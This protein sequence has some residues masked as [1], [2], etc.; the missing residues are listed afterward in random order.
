MLLPLDELIQKYSLN[1]KGVI[2]IGAHKGQE[3]PEYIRLLISPI[4]L[5]EPNP[6]VFAELQQ[7]VGKAKL[8]NVALA[9]FD[10]EREMFASKN[11]EG[12]S[13]S[14]LKPK[15]HLE[16]YPDIVFDYTRLT[17]VT[18]LDKLSLNRSDYNMINMDVQGAELLVLKGG[19]DFLKTIDYIYT[20]VNFAEVYENCAL[21]GDIDEFLS[22]YGF[23][24]VETDSS[25]KTWGDAL[26]V[27]KS[28][29]LEKALIDQSPSSLPTIPQSFTALVKNHKL[30]I[31]GI[32]DIGAH[33][34]TAMGE[35]L[36]LEIPNIVLIEPN[37]NAFNKLQEYHGRAKLFNLAMLDYQGNQEMYVSPNNEGAAD[38]LLR[39]KLITSLKPEIK[40]NG[41]G[42]V[43]VSSLDRLRLD[44]GMYNMICID[45][46]GTELVALNGGVE[47]LL[48][49]DYIYANVNFKEMYESCVLVGAL[50]AFLA[51]FQ[52]QRIITDTSSVGSGMALYVKKKKSQ[53]VLL[54][55]AQASAINLTNSYLENPENENVVPVPAK[56]RPHMQFDYPED[57]N[58][59]FEEWFYSTFTADNNKGERIYLPIFW[60]SFYVNNGYGKDK[61]AISDL[62]D[63][64][65]TLDTT[66]KYYTIVQYDNGIL[67]D[68]SKLDIK[69]FAMSGNRIDYPLPLIC[70]PHK[71]LF[72]GIKKDILCSFVGRT[73]THPIRQQMIDMLP[74]NNPD[75][76]I[77]TVPHT[78]EEYCKVLARSRYVLAP[79]GHG[80]TSFRI[81][82]ALQYGAVP[83]YISDDLIIPHRR[84]FVEG[85]KINDF[86]MKALS[87][88]INTNEE[89]Y[90]GVIKLSEDGIITNRIEEEVS[91]NYNRFYTYDKN[92]EIIVNS[93]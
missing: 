37:I 13:D 71:Y 51:K 85:I 31:S 14:L 83:I 64:I 36:K 19:K 26:Y 47:F 84:N 38:S 49:I 74:K 22:I 21:I 81:C 25:A 76:Y 20:E 28:A 59:P 9:D 29:Q 5:V 6:E 91:Y 35:Y 93:I 58:T 40:F 4:A 69:V 7:Y 63:F 17:K 65:D 89:H 61:A 72:P 82:E 92:K 41:K 11:N 46:N 50:D 24:R 27:K 43:K 70:P 52:F 16:Q 48:T 73:D 1:I 87:E 12:Q 57:N 86:S 15:I 3:V 34:G 44:I 79:R 88:Q 78:L 62:Q 75:F 55:P 68:V 90:I 8:F 30:N 45:V 67:N 56:F 2:H 10:G 60:T 23:T 66:K 33:T 39:P 42:S 32:I 54:S 18:Q 77:S 53:P 80:Q